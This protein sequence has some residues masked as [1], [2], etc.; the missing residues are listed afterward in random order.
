ME[1][2]DTYSFINNTAKD[3]GEVIYNGG[4][5]A[6]ED[7][8]F[9]DN[10]ATKGSAIFNVCYLTDKRSQFYRNK[11]Q[12]GTFYTIR[13]E[14]H[15]VMDGSV[16]MKNTADQEGRAINSQSNLDMSNCDIT[17]NGARFFGGGIFNDATD[18]LNINDGHIERNKVT[19]SSYTGGG[20]YNRGIRDING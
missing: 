16:S 6:I 4:I 2:N 11:A 15:V 18:T 1:I 10:T 9:F 17:D 7:R 3:E 14:G 19:Y 20:I 13:V 5:L 8:M 12:L